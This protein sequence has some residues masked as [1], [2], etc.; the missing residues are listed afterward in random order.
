MRVKIKLISCRSEWKIREA[1]AE[2]SKKKKKIDQAHGKPH[3]VEV[4]R[5]YKKLINW[6][7]EQL[8]NVKR[9]I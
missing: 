4:I 7:I 5:I 2:R 9:I 6:I 8:N 1:S 3:D